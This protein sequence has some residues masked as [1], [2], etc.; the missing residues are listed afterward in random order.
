KED[1]ANL[2]MKLAET[3]SHRSTRIRAVKVLE[4]LAWEG[5]VPYLRGLIDAGPAYAPSEDHSKASEDEMRRAY[6]LNALV[7]IQGVEELRPLLE[8]LFA[9]KGERM[10]LRETAQVLLRKGADPE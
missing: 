7:E 5:S 3:D 9:N 1:L 2:M 10:R 4:T 6:A 8:K